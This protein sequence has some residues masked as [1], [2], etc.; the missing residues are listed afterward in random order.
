MTARKS[1]VVSALNFNEIM[2]M[3]GKSDQNDRLIGGAI[4]FDT[5]TD[6]LRKVCG[7]RGRFESLSN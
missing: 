7:S 6:K 4:I 3:G 2:I 1:C 5:K